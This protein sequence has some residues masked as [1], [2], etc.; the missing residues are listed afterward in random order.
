MNCDVNSELKSDL[1]NWNL[2]FWAKSQ[3]SEFWTYISQFC[4][5]LLIVTY[6]LRLRETNFELRDINFFSFFWGGGG[7]GG[8]E[9]GFLEYKYKI[10][11]APSK[12]ARGSPD[13]IMCI[14]V[15]C[16]L[17]MHYMNIKWEIMV[18]KSNICAKS[19]VSQA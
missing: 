4:L 8:V 15:S 16:V 2:K 12:G 1:Q 14:T 13:F 17:K 7:G 19:S 18:I 9:T 3:K 6:F 10:F 11:E 5:Y